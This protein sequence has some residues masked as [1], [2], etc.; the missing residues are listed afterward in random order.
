MR[1]T[2]IRIPSDDPFA[3]TTIYAL[4]PFCYFGNGRDDMVEGCCGGVV[5]VEWNL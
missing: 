2:G 5:C 1:R 4:R 3:E